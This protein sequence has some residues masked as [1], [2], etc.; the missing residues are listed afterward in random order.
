MHLLHR[1]GFR[2][3]GSELSVEG[4]EAFPS[5]A[6]PPGEGPPAPTRRG[7][8][9]WR[10]VTVLATLAILEAI[11]TGL[12]LYQTFRVSEAVASAGAPPMLPSVI[13]APCT[14]GAEAAE[15][16]ASP[17]TP[18]AAAGKPGSPADGTAHS[19]ATGTA[20]NTARPA[21]VPPGLIGG[22]ISISAP[23]PMRVS[24]RGRVVG[25]TE[26]E[27]I[28][29]PIGTHELVFVNDQAGYEARQSVS[30][31]AGRTTR[32]ALKPPL[33]T[34]NI[35]AAPWAE[36]WVD[37]QRVGDTPIGNLQV[38][39]GTREFVFRHPQLGEKRK[40]AFVT[41]KEPVR[42]SMDMRIK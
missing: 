17:G 1:L 33:G 13:A 27:T 10:L 4:F 6:S 39:I 32:I 2:R 38:V 34:V 35:N 20:G 19:V 22:L 42:V 29:L 28:M 7:S 24:S 30:V 26:A 12:W 25:T 16:A 41:L 18:A 9:P 11:P 21:A 14:A 8:Q 40:T 31:Q 36:V 5:E 23:L 15:P 37:N 3:R